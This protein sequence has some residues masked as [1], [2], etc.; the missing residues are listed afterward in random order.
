MSAIVTRQRLPKRSPETNASNTLH[1]NPLKP[2]GEQHHEPDDGYR[3]SCE[4]VRIESQPRN[5]GPAVRHDPAC[6]RCGDAGRHRDRP[7]RRIPRVGRP[8]N[9]RDRRPDAHHLPCCGR[10]TR[11]HQGFRTH[12]RLGPRGGRH[13]LAGRGAERALRRLQPVRHVALRR[14]DG[15]ADVPDDPPGGRL[16]E[17][18]IVFRGG[19]GR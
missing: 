2:E 11:R 17:R 8:E 13:G 16:S 5:G 4:S 1:T 19:L 14:L 12:H 10:R 15:L 9:G 3:I 6:R 18:Q 7:R